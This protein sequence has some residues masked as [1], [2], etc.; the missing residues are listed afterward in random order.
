MGDSSWKIDAERFQD[1]INFLALDT[2]RIIV[3]SDT[4]RII[5][6]L[7][8]DTRRI[9]VASDRDTQRDPLYGP[10]LQYRFVFQKTSRRLSNF[11]EVERMK[12][13]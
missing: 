9:I 3:A 11:G 5:L 12:Y 4:R 13:A 10:L 7:D 1:R 2:R 8:S 6:A